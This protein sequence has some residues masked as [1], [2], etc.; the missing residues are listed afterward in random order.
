[1]T[2]VQLNYY[3]VLVLWKK[4]VYVFLSSCLTLIPQVWYCYCY[5][6]GYTCTISVMI[7][8]NQKC[9]LAFKADE[10]S[11]LWILISLLCII[12]QIHFVSLETI[13]FKCNFIFTVLTGMLQWSLWR[14]LVH[15]SSIISPKTHHFNTS[16]ILHHLFFHD[17]SWSDN[18]FYCNN[19][20][21]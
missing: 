4:K 14:D 1:M 12:I 15:L 20:S 10:Y 17:F 11:F 9:F 18:S 7:V 3:F 8:L 6:N 16:S 2:F 13:L 5:L 21:W 19:C